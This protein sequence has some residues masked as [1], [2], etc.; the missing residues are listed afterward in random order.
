MIYAV[1]FALLLH[2]SQSYLIDEIYPR[3]NQEH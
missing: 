2:S 3:P 1:Y